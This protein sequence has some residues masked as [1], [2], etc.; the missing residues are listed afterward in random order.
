MHPQIN[1]SVHRERLHRVQ[2][3]AHD[4]EVRVR[5]RQRVQPGVAQGVDARVLVKPG[6]AADRQL[7]LQVLQA[8][9]AEVALQA[10]DL[11]GGQVVLHRT[12]L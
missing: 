9:D 3:D 10:E 7:L 5:E 4:G 1:R 8:A 2:H 11:R 12:H 6:V